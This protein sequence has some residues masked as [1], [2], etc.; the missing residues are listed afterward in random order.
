[1]AK[2]ESH[3]R[4]LVFGCGAV[5][6]LALAVILLTSGPYPDT[7][8]AIGRPQHI[9]WI[10]VVAV[11][12]IGLMAAVRGD[13]RLVQQRRATELL[14]SRLRL[15]EAQRDIDRATQQLGRTVSDKAMRELN[16]RLS[17]A[18]KELAAQQ[19]RGDAAAFQAGVEEIRGRQ[20]T[21]K[22]K[23]AEAITPRKSVERLFTEYESTQQDIERTLT[24]I[25]VDQKGDNLDGRIGNLAQFTKITGSRLQELEHARQMLLNME[26]EFAALEDRLAPLKDE[27]GGIKG[28]IQQL[29]NINAQL[30]AGIEG[31]ERE[32]GVSLAER[33]QRITDNRRELS[34]RIANLAEE[35]GK[36]DDSHRDMSSL[37]ARLSHEL[38]A[39]SPSGIEVGSGAARKT[40]A[41]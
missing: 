11:S 10:F 4:P 26:K 33:V 29:H 14:E 25:E 36:L 6:A 27:R 39:R 1:M 13:Q 17:R 24:G 5:L 3:M 23:L 22:E 37:F 38:N 41:E 30:L 20:Q 16:E 19:Q 32:G 34:Q 18:E 12:V 15:E 9:A 28:M 7:L 31:M 2:L 40:A 8:F 35:L 21:L